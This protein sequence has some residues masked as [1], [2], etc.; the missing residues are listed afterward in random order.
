MGI[1]Q[2]LW[3]GLALLFFA[4]W[5]DASHAQ[6]KRRKSKRNQPV[7]Q[8]TYVAPVQE[9]VETAPLA[10]IIDSINDLSDVTKMPVRLNALFLLPFREDRIPFRDSLVIDSL[11]SPTIPI[12]TLR[13]IDTIGL[14][15]QIELRRDMQTALEMYYG[16]QYAIDSA[17]TYQIKVQPRFIDTQLSPG[18]VTD[19]AQTDTVSSDFIVGPIS[20]RVARQYLL[21]RKDKVTPV[22]V[23]FMQAQP[24]IDGAVYYGSTV[25]TKMREKML[26]YALSQYRGERVFLIADSDQQEA[27]S[28][29]IEVFEEA[30]DVPLVDDLAIEQLPQ[31]RDSIV[32]SLIPN[33]AFLETNQSGL[34]ASVVSI[35]NG[36]NAEPVKSMRLFTTT[37]SVVYFN[38]QVN[39]VHLSNLIFAYPEVYGRPTDTFVQGFKKKF[40]FN[41]SITTTRAFDLTLDAIFRVMVN[42]RKANADSIL[43]Q[44][45]QRYAGSDIDYE[46]LDGNSFQNVAYRLKWV[47]DLNFVALDSTIAP[48]LF[49]PWPE[50]PD[51]WLADRLLAIE[52]MRFPER[53]D[54]D[55]ERIEEEDTQEDY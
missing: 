1:K 33:W 26:S 32:D 9:E 30:Y 24:D 50:I 10:Q 22:F 41:P 54:E 25:A 51:T 39:P 21:N 42:R 55:G 28:L 52:K 27:R 15:R 35:L 53:F 23:P 14:V 48:E 12:D 38:D 29:V 20:P 36:I 8:E 46:T 31:F 37:P 44:S 17:A 19:F 11:Y 18:R 34:A 49:K 2:I 6:S 5:P 40:G 47:R 45:L 43:V 13:F 7:V 4:A 16:I 3:S